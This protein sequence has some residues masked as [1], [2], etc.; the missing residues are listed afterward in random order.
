MTQLL[1]DGL[2][3]RPA[4]PADLDQVAELLTLRGE[5]AD[6]ED[7]QLVVDDPDAG[8]GQDC[9]PVCHKPRRFFAVWHRIEQLIRP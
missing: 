1:G 2:V 7:L 8:E 4:R 3:L 5:A 6:A 9:L